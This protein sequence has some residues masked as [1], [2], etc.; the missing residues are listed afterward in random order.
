MSITPAER[1]VWI[2]L[3]G[4]RCA[5][6]SCSPHEP[7]SLALG[8]LVSEGW[9]GTAADVSNM[10]TAEGP[11]GSTGVLADVDPSRVETMQLLQRHQTLHGCGVR[12]FLDCER[13]L[14]T[15]VAP[16]AG[17]VDAA[18]LLRVLF[19]DAEHAVPDG[20][21]H[22]VA[23]SD[24]VTLTNVAYDVARHCAVDRAIGAAARERQ[25]LT[26]LGLV[27]TARISGAMALK[28]VRSG[29]SWIVGRSIATSLAREIAA[30]YELTLLERAGKGRTR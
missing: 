15:P 14:L 13:G 1:P 25:D 19:A 24:G 26:G 18:A 20:G 10:R 8:H 30:H 17:P 29:A 12:H 3:N 11:G 16:A 28:A 2:A 6:L 5:A 9:I 4:V 21:L 7:E 23:V 27:S 22:A